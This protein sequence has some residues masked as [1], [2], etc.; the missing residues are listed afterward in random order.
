MEIFVHAPYPN[1]FNPVV[2]FQID[3]PSPANVEVNVINLMG[4]KVVML[5]KED[6]T[7]GSHLIQWNGRT[8]DEQSAPTG[9]YFIQC[10]INRQTWL[11]KIT[12]LR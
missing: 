8:R 11:K 9:V 5:L 4:Q 2:H 6:L 1:P 3:L 7:S 10:K 12:L